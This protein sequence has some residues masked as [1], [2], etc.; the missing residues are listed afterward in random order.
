M[1]DG[2]NQ[3]LGAGALEL[4]LTEDGLI[5][6]SRQEPQVSTKTMTGYM[7]VGH[8]QLWSVKSGGQLGAAS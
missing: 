1:P 2:K 3:E 7:L 8:V 4:S 5:I 6:R